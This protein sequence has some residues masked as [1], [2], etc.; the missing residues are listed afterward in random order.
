MTMSKLKRCKLFNDECRVWNMDITGVARRSYM[1]GYMEEE[2]HVLNMLNT[3]G[4]SRDL[5]IMSPSEKN[6]YLRNYSKY[7]NRSTDELNVFY[8]KF[9]KTRV[10]LFHV[11]WFILI[12]RI[13]DSS[14][15]NFIMITEQKIF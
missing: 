13:K 12:E 3:R 10:A 4:A 1:I 6:I 8:S 2:L 11:C 7:V 9:N 5:A 15:Q 14:F